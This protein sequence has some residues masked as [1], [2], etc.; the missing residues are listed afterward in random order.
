LALD[1]R[2]GC[3]KA[4]VTGPTERQMTIVCASDVET[5]VKTGGQSV[6]LQGIS[7]WHGD[8]GD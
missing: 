4:E 7:F 6:W 1:A 5:I 8:W 2:Q 3:A